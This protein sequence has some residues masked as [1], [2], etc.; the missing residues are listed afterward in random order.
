VE[1]MAGTAA[2]LLIALRGLPLK[3]RRRCGIS[4]PA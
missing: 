4:R 2:L 3:V 1:A